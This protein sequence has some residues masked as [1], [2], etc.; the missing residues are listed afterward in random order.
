VFRQLVALGYARPDHEAHGAL[1]LTE[2]ARPV[3]K[4][5]RQVE[6]RRDTVR[7]K[8]SSSRRTG[9][10]APANA[11]PD[12]YARLKAWRAEQARTQ[13]VP[14][15]VVFHDSTLAAIAA[16]QPRDIDALSA[17]P[18]IGAKKLERYGEGLLQLMR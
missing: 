13:S 16:A 7:S 10:A 12:L 4:G 1:R 9:T 14:A 11:D 2:A 8:K 15:Y 18:G 6:M 5:D 17:I 3:L